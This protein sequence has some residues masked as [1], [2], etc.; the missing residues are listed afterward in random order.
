MIDAANFPV[1]GLGIEDGVVTYNN[2]PFEGCSSAE[3]LRVSIAIA[4]ATNPTLKILRIKDGSLLDSEGMKIVQGMA[5]K[6]GF[7]IWIE[8][9]DE[10]GEIGIVL[11]DGAVVANN[12]P[13][14]KPALAG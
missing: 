6:H 11:E 3:Q 7:Q 2:I 14:A 10:S 5:T 1:R 4:M 13:V 12:T 8:C 9:V